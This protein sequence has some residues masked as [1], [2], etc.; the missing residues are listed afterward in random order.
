M[1]YQDIFHGGFYETNLML[2]QMSVHLSVNMAT[3][4]EAKF[5]LR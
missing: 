1:H 5:D 3:V 2:Q 4:K